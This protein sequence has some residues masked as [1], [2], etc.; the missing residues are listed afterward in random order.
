MITGA[1]V[2]DFLGLAQ[3]EEWLSDFLAGDA[4][5]AGSWDESL[6]CFLTLTDE[7]LSLIHI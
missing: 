3:G 1:E 2:P 4:T 7:G 5:F 6:D